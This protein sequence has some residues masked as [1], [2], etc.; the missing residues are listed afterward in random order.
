MLSLPLLLGIIAAVLFVWFW[1][2][3]LGARERANRAA[4]QA[5]ERMSLQFL[6]G[7]VAFARLSV[8]RNE[9]GQVRLRRT[10]VFD[11]TEN[12]VERRQGFVMLLGARIE[13]VGFD[14]DQRGAA[15]T[16]RLGS[17][18]NVD[19]NSSNVLDLAEWR[20]RRK[21]LK[22]ADDQ[23]QPPGDKGSGDQGW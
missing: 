3:S 1:Q 7:T 22:P 23:V 2:D 8:A 19:P 5:C 10:Y 11:Y 6:D 15:R 16:Q 4:L 12:S 9:R 13:S 21:R 20:A 14:P 18:V 17:D